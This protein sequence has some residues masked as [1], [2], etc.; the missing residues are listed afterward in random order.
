MEVRRCYECGQS[1]SAGKRVWDGGKWVVKWICRCC[2]GVVM[3]VHNPDHAVAAIYPHY[4]QHVKHGS[5]GIPPDDAKNH[6][7]PPDPPPGPN[8]VPT[9]PNQR[10]WSHDMKR[11]GFPRWVFERRMSSNHRRSRLNPAL[12][13]QMSTGN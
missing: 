3:V 6:P 5:Q 8:I 13:V 1:V 12:L 11:V 9:V 2:A 7:I 10:S 4:A